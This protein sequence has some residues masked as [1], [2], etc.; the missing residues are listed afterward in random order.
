MIFTKA[1][2]VEIFPNVF[3]VTF[4]DLLDYLKKFS[5]CVDD[6]NNPIALS[7]KL[8]VKEIEQRLNEVENKIF[9]ISNTDDSQ[10]LPLVSYINNMTANINPKTNEITRWDLYGFN[11]QGYDD[12]MIRGLLMMFNK[13]DNTKD[14]IKYL[15]KL[16]KKIIELQKDKSAFYKDREMSMLRG[17]RLPYI[18]VDLQQVYGL[19]ASTVIIDK[20]NNRLKIPK[21]LKQTS[22][23]LK[24][25]NLLDFKLPPIDEEEINIYW[26]KQPLYKGISKEQ[27]NHEI[28]ND[29]DRYILP[30]YLLDMLHYNKNDVFIC[31]E[32]V[33]QKPDE[34]R[35]RYS[36][37]KAFK[38]NV[39]CSAR[40]NIADKLTLKFYSNFSHISKDRFYDERTERT[41]LSFNKIIFPHI[42]FKTK[43]LQDLLNDMKQVVIYHTNKDAFVREFEFYGTKYTVATGGIHSQDRPKVY[44]SNKDYVYRHHD[45]TSYYPSIM[46]EY[47]VCPKHL[48]AKPFKE[49]LSFMKETRVLCKHTPD[50]ERHIIENVPN[51]IGAEALKIVINSIYG[52]L[53][54]QMF[55]LYDRFAQMQV[56]INGQLMT[57]T[58]IEE[59]EL[60]GIHVISANTDGIV[61]KLPRNKEE[62]YKQITDKWN[63]TN[64]MSADYEDYEKLV[65][66]DINNYFNIQNIKNKI[67]S[68]FKG[69]L[70]PKQYLKDLKKGYNAP[71][72]ATA[73]YEYFVNNTPVMTTLQNC[74]DILAFCKTQNVGHQFD[75]VY[76][77]KGELII[78]QRHVRYYASK[79]GVIIQK[80][81]KETG[82]LS[83]LI[84]NPVIILNKLD[85]KP[86]IERNIDYYFYNNECYK[87]I[88]PI[89]L[90]ISPNDKANAST[91]SKSGKWNIK[92][93]SRFYNTLFDDYYE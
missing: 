41:A 7:D 26:S 62:L 77:N 92:K 73:V 86:I 21:S 69:D 88:D 68:E 37:T 90:Q 46:I 40:P 31:C 93:Y 66:R 44:I 61:I 52:K 3:S 49:M 84:K 64:K 34:V 19:N 8:T 71:I 42:K 23:N 89:M 29:F 32:M 12:Y 70:D 79:K 43:Q 14:L 57:L 48:L 30:K 1:F 39:L 27:L 15:Y 35:L 60:N 45:Y 78:T 54:S 50:S 5:D 81:H 28:T 91:G 75:V 56:T 17:Y 82:A 87:I 85:D 65:V 22:I 47:N 36:I 59:L 74:N 80:R 20:N 33:R 38:I 55:F 76:E 18:T 10:L 72:V 2:D 11:N 83:S 16:S 25:Y 53:G 51:K 6:N 67:I 9:W 24:W 58:L 13:F 4:I 63:E